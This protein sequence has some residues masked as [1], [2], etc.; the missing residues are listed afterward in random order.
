MPI[1]LSS[2]SMRVSPPANVS[3]FFLKGV[4]LTIG[5]VTCILSAVLFPLLFTELREGFPEYAY[6]I[7]PAL[8]GFYCTPLPFFFALYQAFKLLHFIDRGNA[9]S[10]LS[11]NALRLIKFSAICMS[12]L[13]AVCMP[14]VVTLAEFDDAPGLIVVGMAVVMAPLVVATFA[15]VLQKLIQNAMEM[16]AEHDFTV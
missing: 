7:V 3:T 4:I 5:A 12:A 15:A 13:Y 8:I 10:A 2:F 1:L 16:K 6:V 11:V 9:F 14:L